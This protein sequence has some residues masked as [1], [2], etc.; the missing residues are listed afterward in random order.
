MVFVVEH[1]PKG[2]LNVPG[3]RGSV[4]MH[5]KKYPSRAFVSKDLKR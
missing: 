5:L 3:I 4:T 1:I 2:I